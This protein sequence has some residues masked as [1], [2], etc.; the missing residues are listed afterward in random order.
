MAAIV[1]GGNKFKVILT[2]V[3]HHKQAR[4][5]AVP[6]VK[7]VQSGWWRPWGGAT[8]RTPPTNCTPSARSWWRYLWKHY[9]R[10]WP[11][12][13]VTGE[14]PSQRPVTRSFDV[15]FHMR[16]NKRLSKQSSRWQFETPSCSIWRHCN[17]NN[18]QYVAVKTRSFFFQ[19]SPQR[20]FHSSPV[21][22]SYG[23][24]FVG[25]NSG[26]YLVSAT[27]VIRAITW[28]IGPRFSG[29]RLYIKFIIMT[30]WHKMKCL[31]GVRYNR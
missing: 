26:W 20:S 12:V 19:K 8:P 11:F 18:M 5:T 22:A 2:W 30:S 3:G 7:V 31:N 4:Q 14:F 24:S 25:S 23:V 17:D 13:R 21:K 27:A 16:L 9:P 15:F 28:Y 1:S 29:S 6:L 10:Y